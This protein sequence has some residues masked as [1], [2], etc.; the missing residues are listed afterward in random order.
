MR[1]GRRTIVVELEK[2]NHRHVIR[3]Q[4]LLEILVDELP[5]L[6]R[7]YNETAVSEDERNR[8]EQ[9]QHEKEREQQ[10]LQQL[11]QLHLHHATRVPT[12]DKD[13]AAESTPADSSK[14]MAGEAEP[15]SNE[16]LIDKYTRLTRRLESLLQTAQSRLVELRAK[17]TTPGS[18]VPPASDAET[19]A[20]SATELDLHDCTSMLD[21]HHQLDSHSEC[22]HHPTA[23]VPELRGPFSAGQGEAE[24][25]DIADRDDEQF[26]DPLLE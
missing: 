10:Q 9:Q 14:M 5:K 12:T 8:V 2:I 1:D 21:E 19:A 15:E 13:E 6:R 17:S 23:E 25:H 26:D 16:A 20:A 24:L 3:S 7:Y 11:Q 18:A 4:K 22:V